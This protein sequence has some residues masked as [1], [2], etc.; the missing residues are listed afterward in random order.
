MLPLTEQPRDGRA[1]PGW[2]F[3]AALEDPREHSLLDLA[4]RRGDRAR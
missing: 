1:F 3:A 2:E 4:E